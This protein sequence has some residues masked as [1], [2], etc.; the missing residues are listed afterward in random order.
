MLTSILNLYHGADILHNSYR[1][2]SYIP[3]LLG[4]YAI[5]CSLHV[6]TGS[7]TEVKWLG[8]DLCPYKW[9]GVKLLS[10]AICKDGKDP[11]ESQSVQVILVIHFLSVH[12]SIRSHPE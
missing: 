10:E 1:M 9:P 6:G 2:F 3:L 4:R 8:K 11:G 7:M 5:I 12:T